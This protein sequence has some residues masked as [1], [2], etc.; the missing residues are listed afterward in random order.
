[1]LV[2]CI[3]ICDLCE[4]FVYIISEFL[5]WSIDI[6]H[7]QM[8][9]SKLQNINDIYMIQVDLVDKGRLITKLALYLVLYVLLCL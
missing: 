9:L 2:L 8:N 3:S 7:I 4:H 6:I 5:Y 1:M